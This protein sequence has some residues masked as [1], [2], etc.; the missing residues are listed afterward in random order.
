LLTAQPS[1]VVLAE[2]PVLRGPDRQCS[3]ADGN[4]QERKAEQ[5]RDQ[6]PAADG[7]HGI[8]SKRPVHAHDEASQ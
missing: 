8:E 7:A 1:Y 5:V 4:K 6:R 3:E 2:D